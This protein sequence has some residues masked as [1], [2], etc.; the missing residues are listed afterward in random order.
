MFDQDNGGSISAEELKQ[1]LGIGKNIDESV[2]NDII[3]EVD[4]NGDGEIS[5]EEFSI[6]ME[7]L[8]F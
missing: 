8:L 2:W 7:R 6:M 3:K 1:V 4:V 5:F